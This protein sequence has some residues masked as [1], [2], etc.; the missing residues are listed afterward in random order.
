MATSCHQAYN[1][2]REIQRGNSGG[3]PMK[4]ATEYLTF[5]IPARMGFVNITPQVEEIVR[6]SGVAEGI[7]FCKPIH[8]SVL[9][10]PPRL[11]AQ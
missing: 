9:L 10:D 3:R 4:S 11:S 5:N 6:K 1:S 7:V 8:R 2:T